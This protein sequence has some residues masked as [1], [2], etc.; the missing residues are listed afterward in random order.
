VHLVGFIII[1]DYGLF[2]VDVRGLLCVESNERMI[3]HN[4]LEGK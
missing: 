3:S 1:I 2:K 4:E